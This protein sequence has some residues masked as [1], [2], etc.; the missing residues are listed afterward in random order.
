MKVYLDSSALVKLYVP[1][2]ESEALSKRMQGLPIPFTHF[3]ELEV[4]NAIMLR[5]FRNPE[6]APMGFKISELIDMDLENRV[7]FR[8]ELIWTEVMKR[9][10]HLSMLYTSEI[11]SRSLDIIHV[12]AA[13][14][15]KC[16]T[17]ITY[18]ARQAKL[19]RAAGLR[20]KEIRIS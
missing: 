9:A 3:H 16:E 13:V 6:I 17:F 7:L 14:E 10:V 20:I 2:V 19:A 8:P 15:L 5:C 1:E 12:A 18:D 11:G 4:K